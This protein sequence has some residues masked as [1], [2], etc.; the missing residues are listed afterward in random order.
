MTEV[1][2]IETQILGTARVVV[3]YFTRE[4]GI[5]P[6]AGRGFEQTSSASAG[7]G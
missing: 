3:T 7:G 1:H 5:H 6:Q 4:K 2:D